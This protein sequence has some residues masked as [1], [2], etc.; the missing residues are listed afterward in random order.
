MHNVNLHPDDLFVWNSDRRD[1]PNTARAAHVFIFRRATPSGRWP[2]TDHYNTAMMMTVGEALDELIETLVWRT[3]TLVGVETLPQ[4]WLDASGVKGDPRAQVMA[5]YGKALNG[6]WV[7]DD[8]REECMSK[9][10]FMDLD[11]YRASVD[12]SARRWRRRRRDGRS[13]MHTV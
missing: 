10:T 7:E 11:E 3:V 8:E 5:H 4:K 2:V 6:F 9:I 13:G 1:K 12:L